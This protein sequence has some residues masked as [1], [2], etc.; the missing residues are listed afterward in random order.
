[1]PAAAQLAGHPPGQARRQARPPG[2]GRGTARFS[3]SNPP[4]KFTFRPQ[5]VPICTLPI[6]SVEVDRFSA[7]CG[8][9][10]REISGL[11]DMSYERSHS[12]T[13]DQMVNPGA[14]LPGS[15]VDA[16]LD[17]V[18]AETAALEARIADVRRG[19]GAL[20]NG[21]VTED[22]LDPGLLDSLR[23][24]AAAQ[25]APFV[26]EAEASASAAASS[27]LGSAASAA[28][29]AGH[30][31][32]AAGHA[33][34]SSADVELALQA[35]EGA[36]AA[37]SA[38]EQSA[39]SASNSRNLAEG[40]AASATLSKRQAAQWAE[41]LAGPVEV[42][43]VPPDGLPPEA[44]ESGYFSARW[45]ANRAEQIVDLT[46]TWYLGPFAGAPTQSVLG[47]QLVEGMYYW[48]TV[49]KEFYVWGGGDWYRFGLSSGIATDVVT[50]D[51]TSDLEATVWDAFNEYANR[52]AYE[53][54]VG[55]LVF[56]AWPSVGG[57]T[58]MYRGTGLS[59]V[60]ATAQSD[61]IDFTAGVY[62]P[63]SHFRSNA[64][65]AEILHDDE[66]YLRTADEE[67]R[68]LYDVKL[69]DGGFAVSTLTVGPLLGQLSNLEVWRGTVDGILGGIDADLT[70]IG[71]QVGTLQTTVGE[72]DASL[73]AQVGLLTAA[74]GEADSRAVVAGTLAQGLQ[75]RIDD[76]VTGLSA[77]AQAAD[78]L[79]VRVEATETEVTSQATRLTAIETGVT[80]P[81][82]EAIEANATAI[83]QLSTRVTSVEGQVTSQSASLTTLTSRVTSAEGVNA[84]QASAISSLQTE[85]SQYSSVSGRVTTLESAV[86]NQST[87]LN[88]VYESLTG[89]SADTALAVSGLA[90][91]VDG[92]DARATV[93]EDR[94]DVEASKVTSLQASVAGIL[95]GSELIPGIEANSNAVDTLSTR[96]TAAEGS[97][98]SQASRITDLE[99]GITVPGLEGI[100]INASAISAL[101]ARVTSS[102]GDITG[103]SSLTTSLDARLDTA[104]GTLTSQG[105]AISSLT[106]EVTALSSLSGAVTTLQSEMN[107]AESG[108]S[109]NAS[110]IDAL[111]TRV[112]N[113]EGVNTSQASS[114]TTLNSNLN[115]VINGTTALPG[116]TAN[117]QAISSLTT[118]VTSAESSLVSQASRITDLETGVTVPGLE[119]IAINA[120]AIDELTT[121]V[122][123]AEGVN[124]A[125][126]TSLTS[127]TTRITNAEGVNT[128]QASAITTLQ[129]SVSNLSSLASRVT[130]LEAEIP[131][132]DANASAISALTT[133]VSAA[134]GVNT[135]QASSITTLSS[136]LNKVINGTTVL[137]GITA[138]ANAISSLTTRV[139]GAENNISSQS[140][141]ITS[142]TNRI[143]AA[144]G[145]NTSQAT[146][147]SSLQ[148]SVAQFVAEAERIDSLESA[149]Y[150]PTTGLSATASALTSL[151]TRVTNAEGAISAQASSLTSLSTTV[152]G[153][154]TSISQQLSSINGIQGKYGVKIDNNGY[155][156]GFGLISEANNGAV[157]ST[158]DVLASSF[159]VRH[160]GAPAI[161]PFE[162]VGGAVKMNGA[163]VKDGSITAGALSVANLAA[164]AA[165]MGTVTGGLFRTAAS[166][167]RAEVGEGTYP[168]WFGT[169]TKNDANALFYVKSDGSAFFGGTLKAGAIDTANLVNGSVTQ[170]RHKRNP[171]TMNTVSNTLNPSAYATLVESDEFVVPDIDGLGSLVDVMIN[172]CSMTS[173]DN[174]GAASVRWRIA[175]IRTSVTGTASGTPYDQSIANGWKS[176][177]WAYTIVDRVAPGTYKWAVWCGTSSVKQVFDTSITV[178]VI[179]K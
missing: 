155:V 159:K 107:S 147:I 64:E 99:T 85:T 93:L 77:V 102:E 125:Q 161:V 124:T 30:V 61:W 130:T 176:T 47:V 116:I 146:A 139:T 83:N 80:V 108:I 140:T 94:A 73:T 141:S 154:T 65:S 27:A 43:E 133:R 76:P 62:A 179:K 117:A 113:A 138:N 119:G 10:V 33:A 87:G 148:S 35:R 5:P 14:A 72:L 120:A 52:N 112:T 96:V 6:E 34:M 98:T 153:H 150:N 170:V 103:L 56:F 149:L 171:V 175:R 46:S 12:F 58:Y 55:A 92:L 111:T 18:A 101:D 128:A 173:G 37:S 177:S 48:D 152:G 163:V 67:I 26:V 3:L 74:I 134:E 23:G 70:L 110:A 109:S 118:R 145:V 168:F 59:P 16:E 42:S 104:E 142:L 44:V 19:D 82:L 21:I 11:D 90:S 13:D 178:Q 66:V 166:G 63:L 20:A 25:V 31:A 84:S 158:F 1:M 57:E 7:D 71:G 162:V 51:A 60:W 4:T 29:A 75:A 122:T 106:T 86:N 79:A 156:S 22:S 50:S 115:K 136:N 129:S 160:P 95:D 39:V 91:A 114:I 165:T 132:I 28:E 24:D 143:T 81:G 174:T 97:L 169:N 9:L 89:L 53:R 49:D 45:W 123:A 144:E 17:A 69:P 78:L 68:A 100:A 8:I 105:S 131:G 137:P 36:E 151:T 32:A 164:V 40:S 38:A 54:S 41:Y 127:L 126:A 121:R 88:A 172:F 167:Y 157:V 2:D 135:S 15:Q